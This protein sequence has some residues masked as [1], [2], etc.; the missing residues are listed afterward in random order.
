MMHRTAL[1]LLY[2]HTVSFLSGS[3]GTEQIH[4]K[5]RWLRNNVSSFLLFHPSIRRHS[6]SAGS[7]HCTDRRELFAILFCSLLACHHALLFTVGG[8]K[9]KRGREEKIQFCEA[10]VG[11]AFCHS[12]PHREAAAA[13]VAAPFGQFTQREIS[14]VWGEFFAL[15]NYSMYLVS[16]RWRLYIQDLEEEGGD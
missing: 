13:A 1:I 5:P 7:I 6:T 16:L 4:S 14:A 9:W 15:S 8:N 11:T 3:V 12:L 10:K 2:V